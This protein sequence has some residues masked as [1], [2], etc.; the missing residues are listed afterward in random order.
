MFGR[1]KQRDKPRGAVAQTV[2][3]PFG[4]SDLLIPARAAVMTRAERELYASLRE[5]VPVIDAALGKIVRLVG[6]FHIISD[7]RRCQEEAERFVRGVRVNGSCEGLHSFIC[8]YL[9]SLLTY[10]EAVGEML[11]DVGG[12]GIAALYNANLNDVEIRANGSPLDL[13]VC[14][15]KGG[16][17][18]PVRYPQ[19]VLVSLLNQ[20][21]GTAR[22]TSLLSGLPFV[23]SVLLRIFTSLKHNWERAGDIR[24]AVTY[25][26]DSG[27]FSEENAKLIADEWRKAMRSDSVCDFVSVGDVSVKVIGAESRMPDCEVPMRALLE[28]IVAKLGIPPFLLGLS[29]STTEKMSEQQAD[30]LTSELEYYRAALEPVIR[31]VV[32][33]H[34]L[35]SGCNERFEVKW[36]D[37]NLQDAVELSS[38]R[39]NNAQAERLEKETEAA[40]GR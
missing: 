26:P 37:I 1:K 7:S 6:S 29:W 21:A 17:S 13:E 19:L 25:K 27:V 34:L 24:F 5:S 30:I 38:A 14:C 16:E 9:D 33:T 39:L 12:N 18:R 36:D 28:Q 15:R 3:R 11:P 8:S 31:R 32:R 2:P 4:A 22:G 40:Y 20:K 23:S 35:L 10:G